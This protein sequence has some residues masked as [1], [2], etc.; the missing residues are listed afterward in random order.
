MCC[1]CSIAAASHRG[2]D[3]RANGLNYGVLFVAWP[4]GHWYKDRA[5]IQVTTSVQAATAN[6]A[7]QI[8]GAIARSFALR[9][10][11]NFCGTYVPRRSIQ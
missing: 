8:G 2:L 1:A 6:Q 9:L 5:V 10:D 4:Q 3:L 11:P 7:R